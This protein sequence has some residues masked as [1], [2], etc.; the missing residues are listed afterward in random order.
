M[1]AADER[2]E[3]TR[4]YK[5]RLRKRRVV[6]IVEKDKHI[7]KKTNLHLLKLSKGEER[8]ATPIGGRRAASPLLRQSVHCLWV[9]NRS[10]VPTYKTLISSGMKN[11]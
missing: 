4:S 5:R 2:E 7:R 8:E 3:K 11:P 10:F 6:K 1:T 9:R